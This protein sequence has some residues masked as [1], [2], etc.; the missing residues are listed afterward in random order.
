[1][2]KEI[3]KAEVVKHERITISIWLIPITALLISLWLAYQYFSQLGPEITIEF[4]SS[5]GLKVK[6]SQVKFRDVP[7]GVVQKISLKSAGKSVIVTVRIN[8]DAEQF[9]NSNAKFWIVKP[10][11]DKTGITG[12]ETLVSGSYIQLHGVPGTAFRNKFVGLE[13]PYLDIKNIKGKYFKLNAPSSYDLKP[14]SLVYCRNIEV[15]EVK[16]VKLLPEGDFVLFDIFVK[17]PYD[18]FVNAQTQF[19]NLS[20]FRFDMSKARL[21]ISFSSASQ[22][23]YG[24]IAFDAPKKQISQYPLNENY[25]FPLFASKVDAKTK[26]IGYNTSYM[27]TYQMRF[28][29]TLGKLDIGAP[30]RFFDFQ[31]GE[32]INIE[33]SF[34]SI[35]GVIVSKILVDIDTSVFNIDQNRSL[36]HLNNALGKGLVAQLAQSNPLLDNLFIELVYDQN[37]TS[38]KIASAKPYDIFPTRNV[39][40]DDIGQK[41]TTLLNSLTKLTDSSQQPLSDILKNLNTTIKS[42]NTLI[43]GSG[44]EKLPQQVDNTL[45]ELDATLKATQQLIG[46]SSTMSDSISESMNEVNKASKA[47]ERVL[48]KIDN[49]P[50]SLIFGE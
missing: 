49:K 5:S 9:L 27:H 39:T 20:N 4:Q 43:S 42:T 13:E 40:F 1:M 29:Q 16:Q 12:L 47:L 3:P 38:Y 46:S 26:R 25:I 21:D 6:Q 45:K 14:G 22:I 19:W 24:G 34:D 31:I 30:V 50:N 37:K 23:L 17:E 48:R 41:I 44:L 2:P 7:I 28:D 35:K 11:I 36:V 33:S 18:K 10:K 32:V 15:G 8:K